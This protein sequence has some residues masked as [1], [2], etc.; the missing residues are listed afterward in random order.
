MNN[1]TI[2][3][4]NTINTINTINN[5]LLVGG[6]NTMYNLSKEV[7]ALKENGV[8]LNA[9]QI[10]EIRHIFSTPSRYDVLDIVIDTDNNGHTIV[11][12]QIISLSENRLFAVEKAESKMVGLFREG[13]TTTVLAKNFMSKFIQITF[14]DDE[15]A[16]KAEMTNFEIYVSEATGLVFLRGRGRYIELTTNQVYNKLPEGTALYKMLLSTAGD[17]KVSRALYY[18]KDSDKESYKT[19]IENVAP[20]FFKKMPNKLKVKEAAK[21][22]PQMGLLK[23]TG[24]MI[25]YLNNFIIFNSAILDTVSGMSDGYALVNAKYYKDLYNMESEAAAC[26]IAEQCRMGNSQKFTTKT[27]QDELFKVKATEIFNEVIAKAVRTENAN[28]VTE[29]FDANDNLL[30]TVVGELDKATH[31]FDKNTTKGVVDY[32]Y[33]INRGVALMAESHLS[34]GHL[35]SQVNESVVVAAALQGKMDEMEEF[36]NDLFE[37]ELAV[38]VADILAAESKVPSIDDNYSLSILQSVCPNNPIVFRNRYEA[39]ID[40]MKNVISGLSFKLR[41]DDDTNAAFNMLLSCDIAAA[42]GVQVVTGNNV[43]CAGIARKIEVM[44][45]NYDGRFDRAIITKAP[46]MGVFEY[47]NAHFMTFDEIEDRINGLDISEDLKRMLVFNF[48]NAPDGVISF[49]SDSNE[50]AKLA[51]SDN[52]GD[53]VQVFFNEFL[54]KLLN[55]NVVVNIDT[56]KSVKTAGL[57]SSTLAAKINARLGGNIDDIKY[58]ATGEYVGKMLTVD[59]SLIGTVYMMNVNNKMSIGLITFYNNKT[60]AALTEAI[61]G[62]LKPAKKFLAES[63]IS[64][65]YTDKKLVVDDSVV[66][67]EFAETLRTEMSKVVWNKENIIQFLLYCNEIFRLYQEGAID[68]TKTGIYL[69]MIFKCDSLSIERLYALD[70]AIIKEEGDEL[71]KLQKKIVRKN[72]YKASKIDVTNID[73]TKTKIDSMHFVDRIGALENKFVDVVNSQF[74]KILA[75]NLDKFSYT[76]AQM[77][78]FKYTLDEVNE[79]YPEI[80]SQLYTCKIVYNSIM[81]DRASRDELTQEEKDGYSADLDNLSNTVRSLIEKIDFSGYTDTEKNLT[82][83][84]LL[85]GVGCSWSVNNLDQ[86]SSNKFAYSICPEYAYSYF[87][88]GIN[89]TAECD[90]I[91]NGAHLDGQ[92][93]LLSRG[94]SEYGLLTNSRYTGEVVISDGKAYAN[95]SFDYKFADENRAMIIFRKTADMT[96]TRN[97]S[98]VAGDDGV[99]YFYSDVTTDCDAIEVGKMATARLFS[100]VIEEDYYVD[101]ISSITIN[102]RIDGGYNDVEYTVAYLAK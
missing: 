91:S 96:L 20:G 56:A 51:G 93:V 97:S 58:S 10:A 73:G 30:M 68:A 25:D 99:I 86:Y 5:A 38:L 2:N 18:R 71:S 75:D 49:P 43:F 89:Y 62:N 70:T 13:R 24:K 88:G 14:K 23:T 4:N 46:K 42:Y 7:Q 8:V 80:L 47:K 37:T 77:A 40:T 44:G 12:E 33:R 102:T 45:D 67:E 32:R 72:T 94:V 31:I 83:S 55:K 92:T 26:R 64:E 21:K 3:T 76:K 11:R 78:D 22:M 19:I 6:E 69:D 82:I 79:V 34:V 41:F 48:L 52:D 95:K 61:L 60:V 54:T 66:N 50:Y 85:L 15:M 17:Y 53:K 65:G 16:A 101:G 90:V 98:I 84:E 63:G 87:V 28:G 59:E 39:G 29:Y 100:G 35:N 57:E 9:K 1:T 36:Y 27:V 74:R 81:A